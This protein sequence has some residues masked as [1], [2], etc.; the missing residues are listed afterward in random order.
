VGYRVGAESFIADPVEGEQVALHWD[1][2][3]DRLTGAE[4][5]RLKID[6]MRQ[7]ELVS[8]RSDA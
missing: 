1:F 5:A 7:L 4:V 8:Q 2:A 6:L 3:C